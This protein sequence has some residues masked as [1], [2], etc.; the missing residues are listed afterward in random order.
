MLFCS[1]KS[2]SKGKAYRCIQT[3]KK[4]NVSQV[5][6]NHKS[7]RAV[8]SASMTLEAAFIIPFFVFFVL[9]LVYV[10]NLLNYQGRVSTILYDAA[11]NTSKLEY[12]TEDAAAKAVAL[13]RSYS[14]LSKVNT[15]GMG[16]VGSSAAML[17][18]FT[19]LEDEFIKVSVTYTVKSPF[20]FM[21]IK[22]LVCRQFIKIRK[23]VGNEDKGGDDANGTGNDGKKTMVY[24]TD[25][26]SVY[27]TNRNCTYLVLS[28]KTV[29]SSDIENLRN[30]D[31]GKYYS[32]EICIKNKNVTGTVYITGWGDRYHI[33]TN[34]SGLKRGVLTVP[35]ESIPGWNQCSRCAKNS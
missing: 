34:C 32:C 26:G 16:I 35:L 12:N 29:N 19:D 2:K 23:W 21:G 31:G 30:T 10:I 1:V 33:N 18:L 3:D 11:R 20:S 28:I 4:T 9:A 14:E 13:A 6:N 7:K 22:P 15:K 25:T 27:H 17:P 24:I 5:T 8:L